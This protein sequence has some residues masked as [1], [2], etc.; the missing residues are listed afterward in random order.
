MIFNSIRI[1][2]PTETASSPP[3]RSYPDPGMF[4]YIIERVQLFRPTLY[5][6]AFVVLACDRQQVPTKALARKLSNQPIRIEHGIARNTIHLVSSHLD[7]RHQLLPL[8]TSFVYNQEA[9]MQKDV[10]L[11]SQTKNNTKSI[12][13]N[14]VHQTLAFFSK[15]PSTDT[16]NQHQP[17]ELGLQPTQ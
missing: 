5:A 11:F 14:H 7:D 2:Q 1:Y 3:S 4:F 8:C 15:Y 10:Q 16:S 12:P 9:E 6:C 17:S 13:V